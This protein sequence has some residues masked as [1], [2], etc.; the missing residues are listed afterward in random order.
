MV[1]LFEQIK[2]VVEFAEAAYT[3]IPVEIVTTVA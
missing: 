2:E 3:P 1:D